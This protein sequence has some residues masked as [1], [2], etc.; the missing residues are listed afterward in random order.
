MPYATNDGVSIYYERE[1]SDPPLV[2]LSGRTDSL[3]SWR[4]FGYVDV[5]RD[6]YDLILIDPRGHGQSDKPHDPAAYAYQTQVADVT[7]VLDDVGIE[8][9]I[10]WGYSMGGLIGFACLRYAPMYFRAF[11]I[12]GMHPYARDAEQL[13][14]QA[15]RFRA[16]GMAGWVAA[17][18]RLNGPL[19]PRTRARVL[20]NDP[21]ALAATTIAVGAVPSFADDVAHSRVPL[22]IY[23]G[24]DDR[25]TRDRAAEAVAGLAGVTFVTLPGLDHGGAVMRSDMIVPH[26][27]AFLDGLAD[28]SA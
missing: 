6:T 15:E 4:D 21:D 18:E 22:L 16:E 19:P 9:A 7:A 1:G 20:A 26:V 11:I 27:R 24:D 14:Q 5:L 8:R 17:A 2:L 23:A 10:F 25:G 13:R 28:T 12:G 3:D